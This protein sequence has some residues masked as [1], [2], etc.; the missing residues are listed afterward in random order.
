MRPHF[1][2]LRLVRLTQE[3]I[4]QKNSEPG[5][6]WGILPVERIPH[7]VKD[8]FNLGDERRRQTSR[9]L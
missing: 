4:T 3:S 2:T 5:Y 7:H 8:R 1:H 9:D 6:E